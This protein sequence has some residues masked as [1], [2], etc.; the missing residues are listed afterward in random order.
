MIA[1]QAD[2][3]PIRA[4]EPAPMPSIRQDDPLQ[5]KPRIREPVGI[6]PVP[7]DEIGDPAI[8]GL[9]SDGSEVAGAMPEISFSPESSGFFRRPRERFAGPGQPLIQESWDFRPF[10]ISGFFGFLQGSTLID[11]W[12]RANQGVVGGVQLG[13]DCEHYWGFET[14]FAWAEPEVVDS[15][16]A[17]AAQ[18]A[19]DDAAGLAPDD[20]FRHRF[21]GRRHNHVFIWDAHAIFYPWGDSAWRPYLMTGVGATAMRFIDR[22]DVTYTDTLF[23]LPVG[24]G[25]KYRLGDFLAVRMEAADYMAFGGGRTLELIHNVTITGGVEYRFGGSRRAYW[26]WNPGRHYW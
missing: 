19:N 13:W 14:R 23:T 16:R 4:A 18:V 5:F 3:L 7:A 25:V 2:T 21:D 20:R 1:S 15:D 6:S 17:I 24:L 26:P 11:D 12:A 10:S 8:S 22:T 9:E